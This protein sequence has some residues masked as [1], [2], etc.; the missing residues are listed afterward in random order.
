MVNGQSLGKLISQNLVAIITRM[1]KAVTTSSQAPFIGDR[2]LP[3]TPGGGLT[4]SATLSTLLLLRSPT[5]S[6]WNGARN[7]CSHTLTPAF[8]RFFTPTST[9]HYGPVEISPSRTRTAPAWLI[10]GAKRATKLLPLTKSSISFST[11]ELVAPMV[12][13]KT[14]LRVNLGLTNL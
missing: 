4:S 5:L 9:N 8:F 1:H 7:I 14:E 12:G 13:L 11:L 10:R 6:A 2:I 3:T